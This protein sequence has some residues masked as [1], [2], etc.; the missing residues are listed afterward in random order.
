ML[1]ASDKLKLKEFKLD[2]LRLITDN[3]SQVYPLSHSQMPLWYAYCKSPQSSAYNVGFSVRCSVSLCANLL[4]DAMAILLER[5][6]LLRSNIVKKDEAP[7]LCIQQKKSILINEDN[8]ASM[9]LENISELVQSYY[10]KPFSLENDDLIRV[11]LLHT[12]DNGSILLVTIPHIICDGWSLWNITDELS[13]IYESLYQAKQFSPVS[14]NLT[15]SDFVKTQAKFLS[16]PDFSEQLDYWQEKYSTSVETLG[17]PG[18]N[19]SS[20]QN[21]QTLQFNLDTECL[22]EVVSFANATKVSLS[23]FFLAIYTLLLYRYTSNQNIIIGV[24]FLG[25]NLDDYTN[26]LG[27]FINLIG[28]RLS[29][30]INKS[31]AE[32]LEHAHAELQGANNNQDIPFYLLNNH[33]L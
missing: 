18:S 25:R 19:R 30:D 12:K 10:E 23:S 33:I 22:K 28:L 31:F 14:N 4:K 21:W 1:T 5:H 6:E 11:N 16:G 29:V 26:T 2:I 3:Q 9:S 8:V 17:L 32:L 13:K 27:C 24:P 20:I 15:Y 7:Y